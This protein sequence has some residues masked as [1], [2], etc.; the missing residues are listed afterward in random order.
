M[1]ETTLVPHG[2]A[3]VEKSSKPFIPGPKVLNLGG[4]GT[5]KS[6][7]LVTLVQAGL[8]V[9]CIFTEP[10]GMETVSDTLDELKLEADGKCRFHWIYLAPQK[11]NWQALQN[12]ADKINK[13]SFKSLTE[14]GDIDKR[15]YDQWL[16]FISHCGNFVCQRCGKVVGP[17]DELKEGWAVALDSLSGLNE[18][19]MK[20]VVGLK[21]VKAPGDWGV[22]MD[23]LGNYITTFTTSLACLGVI[24]GHL[25]REQDP[26]TGASVFQASTLGQKL[27]PKIGRFFSDTILSKREA[28]KFTW[29]TGALN[30]DLKARN[31]PIS[32]NLQPSYV[33]IVERWHRRIGYRVI[34]G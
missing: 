20:L 24:T 15:Q 28:N 12:V 30:V 17:I 1:T 33:Q 4:G 3:F 6:R 13:F 31:V 25:E 9:A 11:P 7:A 23:N 27:A 18:M 26:N 5:G 8:E 2:E 34:G 21:P 32:D 19:A 29:S 16:T 10:S 14:M 22:A